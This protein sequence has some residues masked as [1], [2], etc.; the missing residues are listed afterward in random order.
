[1]IR[2][3][4]LA[5]AFAYAVSATAHPAISREAAAAEALGTICRADHGRLWGT[6][7]CG[8]L[9]VIDPQTRAVWASQADGEGVLVRGDGGWIGRLPQGV[10]VANTSVEWAGVRWIMVMG[11]LPADD[12][13][14]RVLVAHEAWH[15]VQASIG[16]AS[17]GSENAHLESQ[18]G[19]Y[20]LR[21]ELRAL[22]RAMTTSGRARWDAA[23]DALTFRAAR[24]LAFESVAA[25]EAALDR[26]EGLASYTGVKLGAGRDAFGYAARTLAAY[27]RHNAYARSYAYAS[28]PAYGLL[29]DQRQ[30]GWRAQLGAEAPADLLARA[31]NLRFSDAAVTEAATRYNGLTVASSE[32]ARAEA[33]AQR[34]A[35]LRERFD[36][37]P[38]LILPL[39]Q[40]QMELDPNQV[41]PIE[42]R[43]KSTGCSPSA[44]PGASC[45]P[46]KA[47]SSATISP[48]SLSPAR[49]PAASPDQAGRSASTPA[50]ASRN[51]MNPGWLR[52]PALQE[53]NDRPSSVRAASFPESNHAWCRA[54]LVAPSGGYPQERPARSRHADR[55]TRPCGA[56]ALRPRSDPK[57]HPLPERKRRPFRL[58]QLEQ[59]MIR[60]AID[61][62]AEAL[63][64]R[65]VI[66]QDH[67]S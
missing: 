42:G 9:I 54:S 64:V 37:G 63:W 31:L 26:N 24:L 58:R 44:T 28:G 29:L 46:A 1:M 51:P 53:G 6:D 52:S 36:T 12:T 49:R 19:R 59:P 65:A 30:R 66:A 34:D 50:S 22:R 39:S 15:R 47:D 32:R 5:L 41:T 4:A 60:T 11:P 23:R 2:T 45:G 43:A 55:R 18:N 20:L 56:L 25:Q 3:I 21:L 13:E 35:L 10:T 7:L 33:Q 17:Q 14:L 48:A 61:M 67:P 27:D 62:R 40:M 57:A 8:P 38:R 16:L